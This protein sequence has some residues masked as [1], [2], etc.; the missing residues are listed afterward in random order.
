MGQR[1]SGIVPGFFLFSGMELND[2]AEEVGSGTRLFYFQ[3][4]DLMRG[5]EK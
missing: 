4:W 3:G 1:K 5:Q 2:G